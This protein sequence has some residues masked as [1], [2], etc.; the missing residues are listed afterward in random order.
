MLSSSTL[1]AQASSSQNGAVQADALSE[2]GVNLGL[3]YLQNLNKWGAAPWP[4]ATLAVGGT[5]GP[6]NQN[7]GAA[8]PGTFDLKI[9]RIT[10]TQ[11]VVT[12][13]GNGV[14]SLGTIQ[15]TL[16]AT[17]DVNYFNY[18]V[19]ATNAS[20]LLTSTLPANTTI[21]GDVYTNGPI[22][23]NAHVSGVV[24]ASNGL[25]SGLLK[26]VTGVVATLIPSTA[27]VNH[28]PSY[29]YKGV[30]YNAKVITSL[31]D[32]PANPDPTTNPGGVYKYGGS[33][34]LTGNV[35]I[36]G[37]LVLSSSGSLNVQGINNSITPVSGFPALIVDGDI[38][39]KVNNS[40]LDLNG[41]VYLGGKV[42]KALL[43]GSGSKLNVNG[44]MLFA[45]ST[46]AI[47]PTLVTMIT[48]DRVKASIPDLVPGGNPIPTSVS[49]VAWKN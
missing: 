15:R 38:S 20:S 47:D 46:I 32:I 40:A 37:T 26:L 21:N 13:T 43:T 24:Y 12:S 41:L 30:L 10:P 28:Y 4:T 44:G 49:V 7:L 34:T 31:A 18:G 29:Y 35:N 27:S 42:G 16:T 39:F 45:G 17:V 9:Q 23:N 36:K 33:L 5:Y 6:V 22:T 8:I 25:L 2:S 14:S 3:Y 11:Y 1:Q 19:S 48:Y